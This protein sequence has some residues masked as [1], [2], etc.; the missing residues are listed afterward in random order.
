MKYLFSFLLLV[1]IL[2]CCGQNIDSLKKIASGNY[3]ATERLKAATELGRLYEHKGSY[4]EA[5]DYFRQSADIKDSLDI[6]QKTKQS[7]PESYSRDFIGDV[8][9]SM[10]EKSQTEQDIVKTIDN[11]KSLNDTLA[12]TINYFNLGMLYKEKKLYPKSLDAL[13]NSLQYA[14]QI[15]YADLQKGSLTELADLYERMG[16]YKQSLVYFKK[17][18]TLN[19]KGA[20]SIDELQTK[21]EITQRED[22]I[23]QQQFEI[24]RRNYWVAG[25][26]IFLVLLLLLGY[27]YYKQTKLKQSNIAMQAIIQTEEKERKRIAQDLHDSVSQTMM[28]A[29]I[30]LTVIGGE[31]PFTTDEQ[32]KRFDKAVG[33]VDDGFKEV[34]TISHNMMPWALHKTGLAVVIKQFIENIANSTIAINFFSRGFD[35]PYN[36]TIETILY[37]ILQECVNNVMKHAEASRLDISLIR[38]EQGISLS[39]EDNGKGF[40]TTDPAHYTGMGLNNMQNRIS[41]LKGKIELD[42]HVGKGTLVSAYIPL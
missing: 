14:T 27:I 10:K 24:S 16:D 9:G 22:R 11:K 4:R 26:S 38:D 42:A 40:D 20:K 33:L 19:I 13:Q 28:A 5:L 37:R 2:P 35:E 17:R 32:K 36:D 18:L 1:I 7:S 3:P 29:K 12:L 15:N 8:L 21:Y 39:I 30:N 23:L 31:L 34:R 6:V 41:F 25:I